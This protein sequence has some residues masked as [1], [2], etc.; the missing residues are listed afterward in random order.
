MYHAVAVLQP[1]GHVLDEREQRDELGRQQAA[2]R[3]RGRRSWRGTDWLR[4]VSTSEEL[5]DRRRAAED[6]ERQ[7]VLELDS[8][9]VEAERERK[10]DGARERRDAE[11]VE[12]RRARQ[13]VAAARS[14]RDR[15][16]R[17]EF[18]GTALIA[19]P[20]GRSCRWSLLLPLSPGR[21]GHVSGTPGSPAQRSAVIP[22]T[23]VPL[24]GTARLQHATRPPPTGSAPR[25]AGGEVRRFPSSDPAGGANLPPMRP[26]V[27]L[28]AGIA[29]ARAA[30]TLSRLDR[31]RR[32]HHLPGQAALQAR[33]RRG[34]PAR[35]PAAPRL[36]ARLR[37]ERQDDDRRDGRRDPLP[38][39]AA[40][41]QPRGR[42]PRSP[43]SRR[44]CS[45]PATPSWACSR[46]TRRPCPR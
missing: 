32:R 30:G 8:A 29:A 19:A 42:E 25:R 46:S 1:L 9:V 5:R 34:R 16:R 13:P 43:A 45:R 26:R 4:G 6:R 10:R 44:R 36:R 17:A 21:T 3:R 38:A 14:E 12:H 23:S 2:P 31:R 18:A 22:R 28:A 39:R 7:P 27:P 40:G 33:P 37:H 20:P 24:S 11:E 15:R 41:A 35:R